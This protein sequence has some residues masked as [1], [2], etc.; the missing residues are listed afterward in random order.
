VAAA[1]GKKDR[2]TNHVA[3]HITLLCR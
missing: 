3:R 2:Q 1:T